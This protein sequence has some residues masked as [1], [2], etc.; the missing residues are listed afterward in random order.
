[1]ASEEE[2]RQVREAVARLSLLQAAGIVCSPVHLSIELSVNIAHVESYQTLEK[3]EERP[4][5]GGK[6]GETE[7]VA[8][9]PPEF[10]P[11]IK[12]ASGDEIELTKEQNS[13]FR[14]AW[15]R[16][17]RMGAAAQ[18]I[19][20]QVFPEVGQRAEAVQEQGGEPS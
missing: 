6:K 2:E 1:M 20:V 10:V 17:A 13:I 18:T 3:M 8:S 19:L 7:L 5:E 16:F 12:M 9:D 14:E 4:L 15:A 11:V